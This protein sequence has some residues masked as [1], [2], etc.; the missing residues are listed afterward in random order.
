M[1]FFEG[2][3]RLVKGEPVFQPGDADD[4]YRDQSGK[5]YDMMG[6]KKSAKANVNR[7]SSQKVLPQVVVDNV[8]C[9][10]SGENMDCYFSIQNNSPVRVEVDKIVILGITRELDNYLDPGQE[11]EF[12]VFS[13]ER[14]SNNY[15]NKCQIYFKNVADGDYFM[16]EHVLDLRKEQ[17]GTYYIHRVTFV[18]PVRDV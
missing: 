13:G 7:D 6:D 18:P 11:R 1:G 16:T 4:G 3:G 2:L 12:L 10:L 5:R 8:D 17:D 9:N 14:P 15:A